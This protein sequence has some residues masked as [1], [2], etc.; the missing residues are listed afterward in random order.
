MNRYR[1]ALVPLA[2][3]A[4]LVLPAPLRAGG[5]METMTRG[6]LVAEL[7]DQ[8]GAERAFAVV[9]ADRGA[10]PAVRAEALVRLGVAERAQGKARES[11]QSFLK[12]M[13][14]P[15]RDAQVT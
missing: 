10:P 7:G 2:L 4:G 11:A 12:A 14:S 8:Q 15:G 5:P 6:K 1:R 3:L 9:A 13:E